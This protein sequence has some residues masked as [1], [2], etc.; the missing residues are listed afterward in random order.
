M[1]YIHLF[2]IIKIKYL[3]NFKEK[4][5]N[6][7]NIYNYILSY[8]IKNKMAKNKNKYKIVCKK[9]DFYFKFEYFFIY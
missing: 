7:I 3:M 8:F 9:Y 2:K 4:I 5:M 6:L 1:L